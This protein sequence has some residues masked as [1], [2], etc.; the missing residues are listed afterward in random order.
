MDKAEPCLPGREQQKPKREFL[1]EIS[2]GSG[3]LRAG[4]SATELGLTH[5]SVTKRT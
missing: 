4:L 3:W 5:P 1:A 2:S